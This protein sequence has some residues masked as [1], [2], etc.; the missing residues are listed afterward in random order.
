MIEII[1]LY[2]LPPGSVPPTKLAREVQPQGIMVLHLGSRSVG[3]MRCWNCVLEDLLL[4]WVKGPCETIYDHQA[5]RSL[6]FR[7]LQSNTALRACMT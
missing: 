3:L 1:K 5:K 7:A 6:E 4:Q 2:A